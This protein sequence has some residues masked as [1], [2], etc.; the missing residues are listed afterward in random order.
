MSA[1]QVAAEKPDDRRIP[2]GC[3][4][5]AALPPAL[6]T[7][8]FWRNPHA[9]LEWCRRRYGTT[10]TIKPIGKPPLVFMSRPSDLKDIVTAPA[11]ILHPGAGGSVVAPLVG[12][13]SFMI[14]EEDAHL[15]GRRSIL[16]AFHHRL[17]D[18][19]AE[20]VRE[21][22]TREV[23]CWPTDTPVRLHAHLR[24]LTLRV[25]LLTIFETESERLKELHAALLEM[26][27]ITGS[28]A[29]QEPQLRLLPRWRAS[30]K[31]F[32]ASREQ[33]ERIMTSLIT[34]APDAKSPARGILAALHAS[35]V[36]KNDGSAIE[37]IRETLMS[38]ILA[39]HET[40][41]G[42][43]AWAL[44]L[45]AHNPAVAR[46]LRDDLEADRGQ[47]LAAVVHEVLRHRPVFLFTIP[48]AVQRPFAIAATTYHPPA[49][50]VGCVHLMH[51]DPD[52]YRQPHAFKPERF[53][54]HPPEPGKWM[55][56]GGG[57]KRC[58]G[59]HLALLEIQIVLQAVLSQHDVRP[60]SPRLETARW[61]SVIVT[62]QEGC[63]VVLRRRSRNR[64]S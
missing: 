40:T 45:I 27:A 57:R 47:Y 5:G 62:P 18:R 58:P 32:L 16:P 53:L 55:P 2:G 7:L 19:H 51:H 22:A 17:V 63:Y 14:A 64:N 49:Q 23:A 41:A 44:Q 50:L 61:R 48:R 12:A 38:L 52:I 13:H 26:F 10:F 56:W 24:A 36:H 33:V 4:S 15:N 9:Y 25:I 35:E 37:R 6:Q 43:L 20:K 31:R 8:A 29:L 39:G 30:W 34:Q 21:I 42:E 59:H 60:V 46:R 11:D 54:E 3:P 28:L 1:I